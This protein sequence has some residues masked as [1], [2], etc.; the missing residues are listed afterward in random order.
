MCLGLFDPNFISACFPLLERCSPILMDYAGAEFLRGEEADTTAKW[1]VEFLPGTSK[2][3][4]DIRF[5]RCNVK[6]RSSER[7]HCPPRRPPLTSRGKTLTNRR[8]TSTR[9]ASYLEDSFEP[10]STGQRSGSGDPFS[11]DFCFRSWQIPSTINFS[12]NRIDRSLPPWLRNVIG[13]SDRYAWRLGDSS[14]DS[15]IKPCCRYKNELSSQD[16]RR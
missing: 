11:Q 8:S 16:K 5:L 4:V 7:R 13:I 15:L 12:K 3:E 2:L 1:R 10:R 9:I 6:Y 14:S